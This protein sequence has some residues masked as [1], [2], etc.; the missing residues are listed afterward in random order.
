MVFRRRE[1]GLYCFASLPSE[2]LPFVLL[3]VGCLKSAV[4]ASPVQDSS[5]R[6]SMEP[7]PWEYQLGEPIRVRIHFEN[8]SPEPI[9]IDL[10]TADIE[11]I[12]VT[13]R[14][15][16]DEGEIVK[17]RGGPAPGLAGIQILTV[18]GKGSASHEF[19]LDKLVSPEHAGTY[20]LRVKVQGTNL[21]EV[22]TKI[23]VQPPL[24]ERVERWYTLTID[25]RTEAVA[26]S[27]ALDSLIYARSL[28]AVRF[29]R[30]LLEQSGL[31]PDQVSVCVRSMLAGNQDEAVVQI[32]GLLG[33]LH[34]D[35]EHRAAVLFGLKAYGLGRL[36]PENARKLQ[37]YKREIENAV[38][39]GVSD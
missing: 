18:P 15:L 28:E 13:W 8:P 6:L 39:V 12:S 9:S 10:G 4:A 17:R 27:Q 24:G 2:W 5:L 29:Q 25:P 33:K 16:S 23:C 3:M 35:Q 11:R 38:W 22:S 30:K 37:P 1:M 20:E 21:P 14:S 32:L 7:R 36:S 31:A 19:L 34:D 26:R